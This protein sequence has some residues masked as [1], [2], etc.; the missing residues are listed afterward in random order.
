M[1]P[2]NHWY[3]AG[4]SSELSQRPISRT[5]LGEAM[6]LYRT[7]SGQAVALEDRCCHRAMPLSEGEV[8]GDVLRC[9]YHGLEFAP[10]GACTLIPGQ[11]DIP[12]KACVRAF[13]VVEQDA[14]IW[15][16]PGDPQQADP[17][18]IIAYPYHRPG[19]GWA[20]KSTSWRVQCNWQL[21]QDNLL[22]L[23][24][25]ALVHKTTIGGDNNLHFNTAT[26]VTPTANGVKTRRWMPDSTPPPYYL[27]SVDFPGKVD[28]WQE[29]DATP[30]FLLAYTGGV[31]AG[32]GDGEGPREGGFQVRV[33][34]GLTP[35][36]ET[37]THYFWSKAHN[38]RIDD[39][40]VTQKQ[41]EGT[42]Q[43]FSEDVRVMEL[44]QQRLSDDP[45][46]GLVDIRSD[47]AGLL[48][49]RIVQRMIDEERHAAQAS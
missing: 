46:R 18:R 27:A 20:W 30:A 40:A 35:E 43:V 34:N 14:I 29:F 11:D 44:Q 16:W 22:D 10:S 9:P 32:Q 1:F 6:V 4:W 45:G 19:S 15:I 12:R 49:R 38:F 39:P 33:L 2:R 42:T 41:F 17:D 3:M 24:H 47:G 5:I 8:D 48:M 23:T 36:T 7:A 13:R 37:T 31:E 26:K 21:I 28:R 25:L